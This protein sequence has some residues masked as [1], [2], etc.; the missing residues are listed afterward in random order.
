VWKVRQIRAGITEISWFEQ[1]DKDE[2]GLRKDQHEKYRGSRISVA[3]SL[4]H[5]ILSCS[6]PS[7]T[8]IN[9]CRM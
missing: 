3:G 6:S 9:A 8:H 1:I 7:L 5:E 2:Q 4:Q